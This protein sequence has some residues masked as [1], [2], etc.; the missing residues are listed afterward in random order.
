M[1][2]GRASDERAKDVVLVEH[3]SNEKDTVDGHL[4]SLQH[5]RQQQQQQQQHVLSLSSVI[6]AGTSL[7]P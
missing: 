4:K 2:C 1:K 7:G 6:G 3:A 5:E